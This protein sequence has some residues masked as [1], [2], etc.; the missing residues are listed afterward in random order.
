[1]SWEKFFLFLYYGKI[2]NYI[3]LFY[4][5][6]KN[7]PALWFLINPIKLISIWESKA[8]FVFAYFKPYINEQKYKLLTIKIFSTKHGKQ[9]ADNIANSTEKSVG[10]EKLSTSFNWKT[11]DSLE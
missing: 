7:E 1:M 4:L 10:S 5:W 3:S 8:N 11:A 6:V 9:S 2:I